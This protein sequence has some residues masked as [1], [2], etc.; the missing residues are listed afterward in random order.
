MLLSDFLFFSLL[1]DYSTWSKAML[2]TVTPQRAM[3]T[4]SGLMFDLRS[5]SKSK[6]VIFL[7]CIFVAEIRQVAINCRRLFVV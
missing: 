1:P 5:H 2:E 6:R 7:F 3:L 4:S